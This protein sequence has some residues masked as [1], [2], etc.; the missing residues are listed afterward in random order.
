MAVTPRITIVAHAARLNTV[1]T[2]YTEDRAF[3]VL[4]QG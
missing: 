2:P 4:L 1:G 3:G